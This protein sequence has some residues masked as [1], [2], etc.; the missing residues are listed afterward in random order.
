MGLSAVTDMPEVMRGVHLVGHGGSEMLQFR[1]DVPV[2]RPGPGDVLI[3][4]AAAGVNNT[5]INTRLAWY[6]KKDGAGEDASCSGTP[7]AF[8]RIQGIDV[9]G[10]IVAVGPGV[11]AERIGERV[12]VEPCLREANGAELDQPWFLGSECDGGFAEYCRVAARH[13]WRVDCALTDVELASFP[14]SY[15]TAENMLVRARVTASDRVLVTGA[16]GGVGSAAVQLAKARGAEVIAATSSAR[17]RRLSGSSERTVRSRDRRSWSKHWGV[18]ASMSCSIWSR[19]I[20]GQASWKFCV[21]AVATPSPAPS[22][23]RSSRWMFAR[24]I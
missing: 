24:S 23:G 3:R 21:R 17:R 18:T 15:S 7:L 10:E 1:D 2:P 6:S 14:C 8:P 19:A 13:A 12:L 9:C 4:V 11:A 16:S 20:S 5:D 22:R